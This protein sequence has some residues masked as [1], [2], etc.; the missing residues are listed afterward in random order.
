[1]GV[2]GDRISNPKELSLNTDW[3]SEGDGAPVGSHS[4]AA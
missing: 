3:Q 4:I 2:S 1:M